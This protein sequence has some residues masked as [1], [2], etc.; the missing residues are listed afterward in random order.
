[1]ECFGVARRCEFDRLNTILD[2]ILVSRGENSHEEGTHYRHNRTRRI[3]FSEL[4]LSK[5]YEVHGIIV[6]HQRFITERIDHL[7]QDPHINGVSLFL[8]YG[9]IADSTEPH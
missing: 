5:G 9:D 2:S 1:M 7:Y 4:L 6:A 3:L 8:H